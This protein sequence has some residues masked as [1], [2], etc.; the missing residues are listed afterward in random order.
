MEDDNGAQGPTHLPSS[1]HGSS[2]PGPPGKPSKIMKF[3]AC[4]QATK[5][6]QNWSQS[7]R[8]PC[9]N[10]T[11][12]DI[13]PTYVKSW[14]LQ[15]LPHQM[16]DSGAPDIQI[17]TLKSLKNVTCKQACQKTQLLCQ[18][19]PKTSKWRPRNPSKIDR[20]PSLDPQGL[21]PCAP[22]SPC[23]ARWS[24]RCQIGR[25]KHAK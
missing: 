21:L 20:N 1:S 11:K 10:T 8:K 9:K 7:H 6:H 24:P 19:W 25:N 17:Q 3:Q 14:F 2:A 18:S 13:I 16:L 22:K 5:S 15:Y 4:L 12:I 23:I